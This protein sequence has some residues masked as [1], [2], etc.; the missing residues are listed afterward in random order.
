MTDEDLRAGPRHK[1]VL[2]SRRGLHRL[3]NLAWPGHPTQWRDVPAR[4]QPTMLTTLRLTTGSVLAYLLTLLISGG[5]IDITGALTALLVMQASAYSTLRMG[6]V[7]VGAVLG[8]VLVA[9]LL[10]YWVGLSWWSL[11]LAVGLSLILSKVLRLGE[12][13]I[14]MPISAMLI[15]AVSDP[16]IAAETRVLNT[17]IGAGVGVTF[18]LL[19]PPALPVRPAGDSIRAVA[20][21]ISEPLRHAA[22]GMRAGPITRL[23]VGGW[24][25][26]LRLATRRVDRAAQAVERLKDSRR[27]NPRALGTS[28]VE[29]VLASGL[30]NL[31]GCL[32]AVRALF[33]VMRTEVPTG[34]TPEDPYGAEM[35]DA[36]AVVLDD[37]AD[38]VTGFGDLVIAEAA[39]REEE[40]EHRLDHTLD[41]LRETKAI[42]AELITVQPGGDGSSWLLRGSILAAIEHVLAQLDLEE[43]ARARRE[44]HESQAR[45]ATAHLPSVVQVVLP[46]PELPY[47]RGVVD[48]MTALRGLGN[49][50]KSSRADAGEVSEPEVAP[51]GDHGDPR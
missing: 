13:A 43:R 47:S 49:G 1:L 44:W 9:T 45:R 10:S 51:A 42:L 25:D 3:V 15:L 29:P 19:Y 14:E 50:G 31:E 8:G 39:S 4:L 38:S 33:S 23:Q 36:F 22:E 41:V 34:D 37:L 7:R 24:M 28:D 27:L 21:S 32:L 35:R 12:Q 30:S 5:K 16:A 18:N 17:L 26:G 11:A 40:V 48:A 20:S 6:I 46:H 2:R